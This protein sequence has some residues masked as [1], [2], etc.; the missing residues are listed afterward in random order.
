MG[1]FTPV[2]FTGM[3]SFPCPAQRLPRR[4]APAVD[5]DAETPGCH[6]GGQVRKNVVGD[7]LIF[8]GEPVR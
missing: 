5:A 8:G 3:V 7:V 4:T 2:P 6:Y 1:I